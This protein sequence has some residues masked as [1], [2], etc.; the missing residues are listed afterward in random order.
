MNEVQE[1][2][3]VVQDRLMAA[4]DRA[5]RPVEDVQL[6]AVSKRY[7][8]EAVEAVAD[9]G[10][11][12]FGESRVQEAAEKIPRCRDGL[13]W[14][15]IG[16]LQRNKIRRAVE[17]FSMIHAVD[18]LKLLEAIDRI[19]AESGQRV[20]ALLE[21]NVSGEEAKYGMKPEE[22]P[23]VLEAAVGLHY[24]EVVGLMTMPP[25]A[26]DPEAARPFFRKLRKLRDRVSDQLSFP[27]P[28]LSMGMSH[29]FEVAIEE[30]ATYVR[31]GTALFGAR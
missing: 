16:H 4:C 20:Q 8:A 10:L 30:G 5:G 27:L 15:L 13:D 7:P 18:S 14:H 24:V 17:L 21:V 23:A 1:R 9:C 31:V 22:L 11:R 6:I 19:C 25:W 29:D 28:E 2:V 26:E 12:V 3:D